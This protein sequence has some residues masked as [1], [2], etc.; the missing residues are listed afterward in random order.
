MHKR[1]TLKE[2]ASISNF[3][4]STI[5]KALSDNIE[6]SASTKKRIQ[7]LAKFYN[8]TPNAAARSLKSKRTNTIAV[9]I[10]NILSPYFAKVLLGI[11]Q[12]AS[13]GGYHIITCISDETLEKEANSMQLLGSG[14]VDGFLISLSKETQI[15]NEYYH[16][17]NVLNH[18]LPVV[19]FDRTSKNIDCDK[20]VI[21]DFDAAYKATATLLNAS[22]KNVIFISPISDTNVGFERSRGYEKAF[23]D[24][25]KGTQ[26]P[27]VLSFTDYTL[28][29]NTLGDFLEKNTIDGIIAADEL[30]AIF[31]MNFAIT[32]GFKVPEEIS[33]IGFTDGI[34]SK[35]SN[36]P[37]TIVNQ[38]EVK[39]GKLAAATLIERLKNKTR[40]NYHTKIVETNIIYRK[41]LKNISV[42]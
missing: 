40:N 8:Y 33:V 12:E 23:N 5:S 39:L 32:K 22:C 34:L 35:N 30:S 11:E 3:S 25:F 9:I 41:S 42:L 1:T 24:F 2:L 27:K 38:N 10:P 31:A 6:I 29:G 19:M 28:F 17:Q 20:I 13:S 21:D 26:H 36:P 16:I 14:R 37:L 18:G 4:I 15:K 7:E